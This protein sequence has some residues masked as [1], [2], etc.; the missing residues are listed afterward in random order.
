MWK[1]DQGIQIQRWACFNTKGEQLKLSLIFVLCWYVHIEEYLILFHTEGGCLS[2]KCVVTSHVKAPWLHV[3]KWAIHVCQLWCCIS[4][5]M[6]CLPWNIVTIYAKRCQENF[7]LY[8]YKT[9]LLPYPK[10][11]EHWSP[12]QLRACSFPLL[13]LSNC[14]HC[15]LLGTFMSTGTHFPSPQHLEM[16]ILVFIFELLV[17]GHITSWTSSQRCVFIW[18]I[19]HLWFYWKIMPYEVKVTTLKFEPLGQKRT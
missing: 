17:I 3:Q 12:F 1:I 10:I 6:V 9:S 15:L 18:K 8:V 13:S 19:A 5:W 16:I 14:L 7:N 2:R 11:R 4:I